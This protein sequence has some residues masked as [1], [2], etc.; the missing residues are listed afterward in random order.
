MVS[1]YYSLEGN[2]GHTQAS[3]AANW[4]SLEGVLGVEQFMPC[5]ALHEHEG[6]HTYK[7]RGRTDLRL[8]AAFCLAAGIIQTAGFAQT[9][10]TIGQMR[11]AAE[12]E[13]YWTPQRLLTAKPLDLQP[14]NGFSGLFTCCAAQSG[15]SAGIRAEGAPPKVAVAPNEAK[16]VIPESYLEPPMFGVIPNLTS[17]FGA[18]FTT[19]RVFPDAAVSAYPNR[20]AGKLFFTDPK[21]GDNYVCSAATLRPRIVATAGHCVSQPAMYAAQRYLYTNFLFV[22]AYTKVA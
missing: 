1:L 12:V 20:T 9:G 19:Y 13:A 10:A 15:R 21:T 14:V 7:G 16:I 6:Q 8:T 2:S 17:S 3:I 18:H 11:G 4:D 22:P 5:S